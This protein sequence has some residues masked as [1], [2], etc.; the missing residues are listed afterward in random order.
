MIAYRFKVALFY[1][2]RTYRQIDILDSQ[3][4]E[5]FHEKIF[6]AF[7]RFDEHLYSFFLTRV[8]QRG[9]NKIYDAPEYTVLS[10]FDDN[11]FFPGKK[12][13]SAKGTKIA[14]LGL[15]EKERMYYLFDFGDSWWHE[16]TLLSMHKVDKKSGYPKIIKKVGDSPDQYPDFDEE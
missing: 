7:D 14:S 5:K 10:T 3:T 8:P 4:L 16:I 1:D 13:Y 15:R 6:T 11:P 9:T 12:K 2:K